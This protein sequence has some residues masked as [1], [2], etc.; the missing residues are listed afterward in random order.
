MTTQPLHTIVC[1]NGTGFVKSGFAG[2]NFPVATFPSMIGRPLLRS[3]EFISED[4]ELK[5]IVVGDECAK[6][7]AALEVSY[8][9]TNGVIT[10]FDE[11][12]HLWDYT[13]DRLKISPKESQILLTEPPMNPKAKTRQLVEIMFEHYEF[14]A[15]YIAIQAVLTLCAQGLV[16]GIVLDSGDGVTHTLPVYDGYCCEHLIGRMNLAGREVTDHLINLL[17][18]R[19]YS[20]NRSADIETVRF[21][22]EKFCYVAY[23]LQMENKLNLET[24]E[25]IKVY[26]LPDGRKIKIGAERFQGPECL[27]NPSILD[28]EDAGMHKQIFETINRADLDLRMDYYS[29]IVLSGG[30]T[31]FPGLSSRLEKEIT[32]LYLDKIL[33]GDSERL[34]KFSLRVEDSPRRKHLVFCGGAVLA[35]LMQNEGSK[36]WLTKQ[37]YEEQGFARAIKKIR[38]N[39]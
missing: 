36:F 25:L 6:Y 21:I 3:N 20:F 28:K 2:N 22:K 9:M 12:L 11:M 17:L 39:F 19:G 30:S 13:W 24:T 32:S 33:K 7:R 8:P 35:E 4:Y 37:E 34:K 38:P 16:T 14:S 23:D 29:H 18:M 27:L 1:D 15:L 31:M 10:D 5:D 26:K